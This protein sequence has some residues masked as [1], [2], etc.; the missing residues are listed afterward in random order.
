MHESVAINCDANTQIRSALEYFDT[1]A[2][3]TADNAD[4]KLFRS[5]SR[6]PN[7]IAHERRD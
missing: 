6:H 1:N 7:R 3:P 2:R 5:N 4:L